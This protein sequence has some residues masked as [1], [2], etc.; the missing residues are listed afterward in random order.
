VEL[1]QELRAG[2]LSS[3][4]E[5]HKSKYRSLFPTLALLIELA[6]SASRGESPREVTE[7]SAARAL[8]WITYL[9]GHA[10]RLYFSAEHPE[11]R[12]ARLLLKRI[13]SGDVSHGDQVREVY[14]RQWSGLRSKEEV[15]GALGILSDFGWLK[16]QKLESGGR[17]SE[18]VLLHPTLR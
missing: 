3:A 11:M 9:E 12:S 7:L 17:P 16:V 2:D 1:E 6:D 13:K 5:A 10:T 18:V 15:D 14:R 4:M 8:G